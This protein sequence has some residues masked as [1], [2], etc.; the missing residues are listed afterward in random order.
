MLWCCS[1]IISHILTTKVCLFLVC[2]NFI[3]I[4]R[5]I[6]DANFLSSHGYWSDWYA[7]IG[8]FDCN[9]WDL[10]FV[11][12]YDWD[13]LIVSLKMKAITWII[14]NIS[15][16]VNVGIWWHCYLLLITCLRFDVS[17]VKVFILFSN[18]FPPLWG[19]SWGW[20]GRAGIDC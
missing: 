11:E 8:L 13:C 3:F 19:K 16:L 1:F 10:M 15:C 2:S 4:N 7:S 14:L 6:C 5:S 17:I 20:K 12:D 9:A 18:Y